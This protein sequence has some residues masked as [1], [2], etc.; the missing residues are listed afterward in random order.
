MTRT[1]L[2]VF[3]G[4]AVGLGAHFGWVSHRQPAQADD[5]A[6]QLA[7]MKTNLGLDGEQLARIRAL[8]EHSAPQLLA[9]ARQVVDMKQELAAFER[10]RRTTGRIDFLEFAKFVE[11]RR[12]LNRACLDS[13]RRL[14]AASAGLMTVAQRE[15]YLTMLG[16]VRKSTEASAVP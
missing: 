13:T 1:L 4:M 8:H 16:P 11:Q 2:I 12:E 7:W 5:L 14:V 6:A 10:E 9:L 3:L 15:Q